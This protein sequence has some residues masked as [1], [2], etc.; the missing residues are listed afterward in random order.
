[1]SV[2]TESLILGVI[3]LSAGVATAVAIRKKT[4]RIAVAC[5]I[6]GGAMVLLYGGMDREAK[7]HQAWDAD[8]RER[9]ERLRANNSSR[10]PAESSPSVVVLPNGTV[11]RS[12]AVNL[13]Q[14][15]GGSNN[16]IT[17]QGTRGP[18]GPGEDAN[19]GMGRRRLPGN[20]L[21]SPLH[22]PPSSEPRTSPNQSNDDQ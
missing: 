13:E 6:V 3:A 17:R 5:C 8:W 2:E 22:Q 1:M 20:M 10:V 7:R 9:E 18:I 21:D 15:E 19:R 16:G 14:V 12:N 4:A 11:V